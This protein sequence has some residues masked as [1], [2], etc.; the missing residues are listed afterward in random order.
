MLVAEG[1]ALDGVALLLHAVPLG[2]T[3]DEFKD[4]GVRLVKINAIGAALFH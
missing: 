3:S 1:L 2:R 4:G